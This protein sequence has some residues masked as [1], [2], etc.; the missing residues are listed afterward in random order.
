MT[1]TPYPER[2]G[3]GAASAATAT[4]FPF[5]DGPYRSFS[6]IA[7]GSSSA[8]S[9]LGVSILF[10]G[11]INHPSVDATKP[12]RRA[13]LTTGPT[14]GT[15][16]FIRLSD[17]ACRRLEGFR[18]VMRFGLDVL[19]PGNRFFFGVVSSIGAPANIDHLTATLYSRV[20]IAISA[21]S[22]N[23]QLVHGLINTPPVVLDLG[24]DFPVNTTDILQ[25]AIECAP[26]SSGVDYEVTNIKTGKQASGTITEDIPGPTDFCA[27]LMVGCNNTQATEAV[28]ALYRWTLETPF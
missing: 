14:I 1:V 8:L 11:S 21:N 26:G 18:L 28:F 20:G 9:T 17:S 25:I 27:P 13:T 5:K 6:M 16:A 22:G 23:W 3:L 24:S 7:P 19:C 12:Y 10:N 4:G 15:R 2:G